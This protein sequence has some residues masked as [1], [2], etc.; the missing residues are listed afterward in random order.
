MFSIIN[1]KPDGQENFL[2]KSDIIERI[3]EGLKATGQVETGNVMVD[4]ARLFKDVATSFSIFLREIKNIYMGF[5]V[6]KGDG[7]E[8]EVRYT[9]R[10]SGEFKDTLSK[11]ESAISALTFIRKPIGDQAAWLLEAYV[12]L[13]FVAGDA[14]VALH[15]VLQAEIIHDYR[16]VGVYVTDL[17]RKLEQ[18]ISLLQ[19]VRKTEITDLPDLA[20][21]LQTNPEPPKCGLDPNWGGADKCIESAAT[22]L[23][24]IRILFETLLAQ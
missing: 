21:W 7:S 1:Y 2:L 23:H 17:R 16:I 15:Q 12:N 22:Y 14:G 4:R 24:S 10:V 8:N 13:A 3:A 19:V 11:V 9:K 5:E 6:M 18:S 20:K